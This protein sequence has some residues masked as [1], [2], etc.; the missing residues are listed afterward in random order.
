MKTKILL[1]TFACAALLASC[2]DEMNYREDTGG[3]YDKEYMEQAFSNMR[4]MVTDV[5]SYLDYDYGSWGG[6]FLCSASDES[7]YSIPGVSIETFYNGS[8]SPTNAQSSLYDTNYKAI[9]DANAY[10]DDFS[11]GLKFPE[12]E[13]DDE[14]KDQMEQYINYFPYE[15]R[16]L[17]AYYY[18]QLVR[19]YGALP[20]VTKKI[21][22]NEV[23]NLERTPAKEIFEFI[24]KECAEVAEHLPLQWSQATS[25]VATGEQLRATRIAVLALRARAALYAASPLFN[26]D[27]DQN[28]WKEAAIKNKAVIDACLGE[29]FKLEDY[30]NVWGRNTSV[31]GPTHEIIFVRP[32]GTQN[33]LVRLEQRNFPV[34]INGG[35]GGGNCPTQTF[36]EA[37]DMKDGSLVDWSNPAK[38]VA[39]FSNFD[40]RFTKTVAVNGEKKWPFYNTTALQTYYNGANGQPTTGGTTTSYYLKKLMGSTVDLRSNKNIG[41]RHSWVIF[42]MGEFYLN[43]AEAVYKWLGTETVAPS[44]TE[45]ESGYKASALDALNVTRTRGGVAALTEEQSAERGFWN[46][47]EKERM[48]ELSFEGHRFWDVRRWKEGDKFSG[49]NIYVMNITKNADGTFSY[50]RENLAEERNNWEDKM[51]LF[52][53]PLTE[54]LKHDR[55]GVKWQQN[56]GWE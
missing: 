40:P 34:G 46:C 51:Y 48:I 12:H 35:G 50:E 19:Q 15:V 47:Y 29:G 26:T 3:K 11:E 30:S 24:D 6:A 45:F 32:V 20:L 16:F 49:K 42:R 1:G 44:G 41:E 31:I 22:K 17:R 10:L 27:N 23:N 33:K 8:W 9:S 7:D 5:Y 37:F 28:L 39:Q 55:Y 18:F 43:Y 53:I 38:A 2:S 54:M 14:Y 4:S 56:P 21:D 25:A 36:V 52:P 13:L